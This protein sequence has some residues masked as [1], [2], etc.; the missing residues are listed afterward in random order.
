[1]VNI[2]IIGCGY[3]GPKHARNFHELPEANLVGVCDL[4]QEKLKQIKRQY[5]YLATTS[6]FEELLEDSTEAVVIATPVSTHYQ[7]AKEA[8]LHGKHVMVEK[9]MTCNGREALELIEL[10]EKRSL[11]LMVGH[12][13]EYHPAVDFLARMVSSGELG[14]IY[15]IDAARLNLGL[16][17]PDVNVLWDLA[18]HDLCIVLSLIDKEPTAV[19]ARGRGHID[20]DICDVA[21]LELVFANGT[22]AHLHVSWLDPRKVRQITIVGSKKMAVYDDISES[23]KVRI[24]DKGLVNTIDDNGA[25]T[26]PPHYRYGD[27]NIP[28]ISNAEPLKLECSH[29][30]NCIIE[31]KQPKSDGWAGLK[32]V[33]ILDAANKSLMN[34]GQREKL[35]SVTEV[36]TT[37]I[38]RGKDIYEQ[39]EANI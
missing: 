12:I 38:Y 35:R 13:Y 36:S 20:P 18:P 1:M 22:S 33:S 39:A 27:V 24:Y 29:F 11:V 3:W 4:D 7:L 9:P 37:T 15:S 34:G 16:F 19:S 6:D 14:E 30:I 31:G 26:W 25:A 32:I 17:R 10:A 28:F 2:G 5:P 23:E 21:Y 8:L